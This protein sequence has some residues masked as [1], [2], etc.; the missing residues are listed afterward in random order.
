M[1]DNVVL[2]LLIWFFLYLLLPPIRRW[3]N[4]RI[5][6]THKMILCIPVHLDEERYCRE[7]P[8]ISAYHKKSLC[9]FKEPIFRNYMF[10]VDTDS[11]TFMLSGTQYK[12]RH[13]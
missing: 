4:C 7:T 1:V 8:F 12:Y 5:L 6:R 11:K 3:T 2:I 9:G 13:I 10:V